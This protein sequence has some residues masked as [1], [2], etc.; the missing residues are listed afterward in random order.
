MT[1]PNFA[2]PTTVRLRFVKSFPS[3]GFREFTVA[4]TTPS[5]N[6]GEVV[7]WYVISSGRRTTLFEFLFLKWLWNELTIQEWAFVLSLP[8]FYSSKEFIA[9]ARA[10]ASGV[11]KT[12]IRTRLEKYHSLVGLKQLSRLRYVSMKRIRY[13]LQ[14]VVLTDQ[15]AKKFSGWVRHHND[16]G[17]LRKSSI[18]ELQ[19][20]GF[21]DIVEIDLFKVLSVGTVTILNLEVKL[22][23][24]DDFK[25][26]NGIPR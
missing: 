9:C 6:K 24:D 3:T 23:P 10:L 11:S 5:P 21:T 15:P 26:R 12:D 18:F 14:E 17:S 1:R 16:Q 13:F 20:Q 8:E 19:S 4:S 25:S 7:R 2:N 22:S